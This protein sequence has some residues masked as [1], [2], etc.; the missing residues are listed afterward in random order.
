M[1][2]ALVLVI[3]IF[4]IISACT[5]TQTMPTPTTTP[6]QKP[7]LSRQTTFPE[8]TPTQ[9]PSKTPQP[10]DATALSLSLAPDQEHGKVYQMLEFA[11]QTDG[12]YANPFDPGQ[13]D[14]QVRFTPPAGE[15]I[16]V[17]AFWGQEYDPATLQP[18]GDPGW[19]VRFTPSM[20]GR[21]SAQ[22]IMPDSDLQSPVKV[23]EVT[24]DP[25]ARGFVRI[26]PR[27]PTFFAFENGDTFF[28]VGINMGWGADQPLD[29]YRRWL[30][31]LAA[32]GG[33]IIRIWMA[34]WSFGIEWND[35]PL[36]DYTNRLDRAWQLDQV[37]KMAE[38][39]GIYVV[40][41]LINHGA[42]SATVNPQWH[43]N[44]YNGALGGPLGDP[45]EFATHPEA[46]RLFQQRLRY[47]AARWAAFPNLMAWEWWNEEDWTPIEIPQLIAW[48]KEMTPV[49]RRYDPYHHLI[50]NSL[51]QSIAPEVANLPE[52][53]F[54]QVHLYDPTDP[55][56]SFADMYEQWRA[57]VP[58]KPI[59]FGEFGN[60][61]GI[62]DV[63]S[64]DQ[65]GLHLHNSLWASTFS[66]FAT[67]AMYWWWDLYVD[68]LNLWPVYG[69]LTRFLAGEDLADY[70]PGKAV[71]SSRNVPYRILITS[72]SALLWLHDR[73][74]ETYALQQTRAR[75][76]LEGQ[77]LDATWVYLPEP[78]SGL[79]ITLHDLQDGNYTIHWYSPTLGT[80]L[81]RQALTVT[82][83]Q[84]T[85]EIP[86]FQGDLAAKVLPVSASPPD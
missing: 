14:L 10:Q 28:P 51:A 25:A 44:P 73:K 50:T 46:R 65:Q 23:V 75:L 27:N 60:S 48:V 5:P 33:T 69:R 34:S 55:T 19:K 66:G 83:G 26:H 42:F 1:K 70:A 72:N 47:I 74:Y 24:D 62:E 8:D 67:T 84:G 32:Q 9:P 22:A 6:S 71:L 49:L 68:P 61:A 20:P 2:N 86:P 53:D 45:A 82:A 21:W 81:D 3:L 17:P 41:V 38:E 57:E 15:P 80:W 4:L 37:M 13:V 56:F 54:A 35:T 7:A 36:G 18:T 40:L 16:L 31:R 78:I 63:N 79:S 58:Q 52:I 85:F 12:I 29:D 59:L 30:D 64:P 39:R 76:M 43:E 77:S 11:I